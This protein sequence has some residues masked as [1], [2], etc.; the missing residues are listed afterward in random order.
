MDA[1]DYEPEEGDN[2]YLIDINIDEDLGI[3]TEP[4]EEVT[5]PRRQN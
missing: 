3:E 1:K 5:D 2:F 4:Q